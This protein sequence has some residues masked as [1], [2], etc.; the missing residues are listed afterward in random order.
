MTDRVRSARVPNKT[1]S[2]HGWRR[3]A[4]CRDTEPELFFPI[5]N[6]GPALMQ[7]EEAK[8]VCRSCP[9]TTACLEWALTIGAVGVWGCTTEKERDSLKRRRQRR[10]ASAGISAA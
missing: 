2:G 4:A 9:V 5:G 10:A 7:T 6:S 8:K 1:G 3:R